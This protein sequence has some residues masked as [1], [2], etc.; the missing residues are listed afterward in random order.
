MKNDVND[1]LS[2]SSSSSSNRSNYNHEIDD[3][4]N[5]KDEIFVDE[6]NVFEP[7]FLGE[8]FAF[9]TSLVVSLSS[10][11]AARARK[12]KKLNVNIIIQRVNANC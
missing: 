8:V 5:D 7:S 12:L 11:I 2:S 10:S 1:G 3:D 4:N 9:S 6:V